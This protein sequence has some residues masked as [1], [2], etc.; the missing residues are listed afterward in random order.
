MFRPVAGPGANELQ[1]LVEQIAVAVGQVLERRGLRFLADHGIEWVCDGN[2]Y[3]QGATDGLQLQWNDFSETDLVLAVRPPSGD[4]HLRKPATKLCNAW[5][6]GVPAMLGPESAYRS[7]RRD[8]LDFIEVGAR[9]EAEA[10][11]LRMLQE[12]A[13]YASMRERA[14]ER[15]GAPRADPA[16][17]VACR[18]P[19]H[20]QLA[21]HARIPWHP[22][23]GAAHARPLDPVG[24]A[25]AVR[26][27]RPGAQAPL[28][29]S[30][31]RPAA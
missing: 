21:A 31:L 15:A 7:L 1:R 4:L 8:E 27:L 9:A 10:A 3:A 11:V 16:D 22:A 25:G 5:L 30:R 12:P 17:A 26:C 29:L 14:S 2:V 23:L 28:R 24:A 6:A 20:P 18:A 19:G 13:R